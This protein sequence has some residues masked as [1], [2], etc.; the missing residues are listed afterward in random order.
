MPT[1]MSKAAERSAAKGL[2]PIT[3]YLTCD[4]AAAAIDFYRTAFD[5]EELFRLE[6]PDGRILHACLSLNGGSVM[7]GDEHCEM[8]ASP[9]KLGGSPVTVHLI[10]DDADA[11]A[12]R[13]ESAGAALLM[14]VQEMFWGDRYGV[15][16]DPFGHVWS[17]ATPIRTLSEAEVRAAAEAAMG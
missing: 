8:G 9:Q 3:P 5:A 1:A 13:A 17:V 11:W 7:L 12:A 14:P 4:G 10:V 6:G 16:K 2:S 15:L